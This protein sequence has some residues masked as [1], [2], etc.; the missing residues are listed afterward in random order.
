MEALPAQR[1]GQCL[2]WGWTGWY[3][4]P[5]LAVLYLRWWS[6]NVWLSII[7]R[8]KYRCG[9]I[10]D[11][12]AIY[13][14]DC[15][16]SKSQWHS[17]QHQFNNCWT[18]FTNSYTSF[19]TTHAVSR[20]PSSKAGTQSTKHIT[21]CIW[22]ATQMHQLRLWDWLWLRATCEMYVPRLWSQGVYLIA[23]SKRQD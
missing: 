3:W 19:T 5:G 4:R 6:P 20:A 14:N 13:C 21:E 9:H 22:W 10:Q 16:H 2:L 15:Q 11:R 17:Q 12:R 8:A 1:P 23:Y 7:C 18:S